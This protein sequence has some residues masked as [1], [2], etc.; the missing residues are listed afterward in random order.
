MPRWASLLLLALSC[1]GPHETPG[2]QVKMDFARGS[3]WDAPFPSDELRHDGGVSVTGF[4]TH[5]NALVGTVVAIARKTPG[6]ATSAGV[7]FSLT[8]PIDP[9][10][11]PDL[12]GSVADD[13]AVLLYELQGPTPGR[14][15]PLEV[16]FATD[17]GTYGAANQLVLLPFQGIPLSPAATYAAIVR[18]SL[19]DATGSALGVS[20]ALAELI[21]GRTPDNLDDAAAREYQQAITQ[22]DAA[23][24]T[25]DTL[26]GLA[27]FTTQEPTA[28]MSV[29]RDA[30]LSQPVPQ[31][32]TP[33]ALTDT[34][35]DYCVYSSTIA[36]PSYQSGVSPFQSTGGAW[37]VDT[38]G[39]PILQHAET[40]H[41]TVTVPRAPPPG[42]KGYGVVNF[43]GTGAGGDRP[44]VDR[45]PQGTTGG[46]PLVPGTGPALH[47][48]HAGYVGFTI[49]GPIEG[50]RNTTGGDEDT[51]FVNFN[52]LPALRDNFRESALEL[53]FD[54]KLLKAG[55]LQPDVS[56]CPGATAPLALDL[57]HLVLMGHSLGASVLPLA[58]GVEPAYGAIVLSGS[59]GSWIENVLYKEKP[60]VIRPLAELLAGEQTGAMTRFDP[61]LSFVQWAAE[62]AD[63]PVY[64]T[65]LIQSPPAGAPKRQV[66]MV[67]GIVDHYILPRI[68]NASSVSLGLDL[69]GPALDDNPEYVDQQRALDVLPLVGR[70]A[71]SLPASNNVAG[72]TGVLVQHPEDGIEDG[73]EVLFQT[74]AP[75]HQYRCFLQSW[76][77]GTPTVPVDG[78]ADAGCP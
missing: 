15:I 51:L 33:F 48:A 36:M 24:I 62:C 7:F 43:I 6:F 59:G 66:F 38:S 9:S 49:D 41:V 63:A 37:Q 1:T 52:N 27:V 61:V 32:D 4:D 14:R 3:L 8:A 75:K 35:D 18:R 19:K 53:T 78:P 47:L 20:L 58:A 23:G 72:V 40:A 31:L 34:F 71:I 46:P 30:I 64:E 70:G 44:L 55:V 21:S 2:T 65:R 50:L 69:A 39:A 13:S 17:G 45:G 11:L 56:D 74:E 10:G 77:S 67:Q 28:Q 26:A 68:A 16:G 54:V 76:L 5:G 57:D 22:L 42:P 12:R 73:H 25:H 60:V 29:F